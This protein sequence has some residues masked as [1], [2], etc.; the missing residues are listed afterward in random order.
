MSEAALWK[1]MR[2]GVSEYCFVQRIENGVGAG[3]PDVVLHSRAT[4]KEAWV[5]LKFRKQYPKR[6]DS[7]VFSGGC[8]LR[9]DQKAW[10]YGRALAGVNIWIL[11]QV[12]KDLFLVHGRYARELELMDQEELFRACAWAA[13]DCSARWEELVD[14]LVDALVD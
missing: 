11:G 13:I 5:E 4:G 2:A 1:R 7:A 9:P 10:I 12:E 14:A 3:M 8:G 6:V